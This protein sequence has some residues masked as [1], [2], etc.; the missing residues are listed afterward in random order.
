MPFKIYVVEDHPVMREA[1]DA[2]LR[3]EPDLDPC[4]M[5][6]SAEEA[7]AALGGPDGLACDLVLTDLRLPG[8]SGTDLVRH[9]RA[10]RPS[11]PAVVITAHEDQAFAREARSA[12][13]AAFLRKRDLIETLVPTIHDVLRA[14]RHGAA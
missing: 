9:L 12:G 10:S 14:T 4:G 8:Q 11:L 2:M 7:M 6:A 1:Y 13:A 5:A 3:A